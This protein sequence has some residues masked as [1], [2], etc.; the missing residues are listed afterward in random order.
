VN[1]PRLCTSR[2]ELRPCGFDDLAVLHALWT[3]PDVRRWLWD[4]VVIPRERVAQVIEESLGSFDA[5]GFGVWVIRERTAEEP[6]GFAGLR[7]VEGSGE[8]E[9]LY[10]L[11]PARWGAGL[12][13]EA[14]RAVLSCAFDKL[15]LERIVG[16]VDTPNRA[17]VRVLERLGMR[18]EGEKV[19]DG[20]PTLHFALSRR[21]GRPA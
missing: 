12:A 15:D 13:T 1:A 14:A 11:A 16:R 19:V 4:D 18:P 21:A 2:L 3:D 20:R 6:I 17:S 9:L 5:H 7:F 10:G 8:I